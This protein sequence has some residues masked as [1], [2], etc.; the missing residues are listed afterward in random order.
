[1]NKSF[2]AE[3]GLYREKEDNWDL[4][5]QAEELGFS[6]PRDIVY[7]GHEVIMEVEVRED[8][9]H[10]VLKINGVDVSDKDITI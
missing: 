3:I 9:A 8:L 1:M 6:N 2:I 7:L 10:K 4:E 5:E